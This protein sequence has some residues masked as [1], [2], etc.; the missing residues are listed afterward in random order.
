LV[1]R[2]EQYPILP[3]VGVS[4]RFY[5][6]QT[7]RRDLA[8]YT[9]MVDNIEIPFPII[10]CSMVKKSLNGSGVGE[11]FCKR[12]YESLRVKYLDA[13]GVRGIYI[14]FPRVA[15]RKAV[16]P[17]IRLRPGDVIET[18]I[19]EAGIVAAKESLERCPELA[20]GR[21]RDMF[22]VVNRPLL[23][24]EH[25]IPVFFLFSKVVDRS[26]PDAAALA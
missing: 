16:N 8:E 25:A 6:A 11:I 15:Q 17:L 20:G 4:Q 14:R 7:S 24:V 23:S 22:G 21:L 2:D 26:I 10:N 3:L 18:T 9:F 13:H 19:F 12:H 1:L 5:H